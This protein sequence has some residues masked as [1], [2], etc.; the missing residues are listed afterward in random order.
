MMT[1]TWLS[2]LAGV[3][4]GCCGPG[5][6]TGAVGCG[7]LPSLGGLRPGVCCGA[8]LAV[9]VAWAWVARP[10]FAVSLGDMAKEA[11]DDL[12]TVPLLL[13]IAFYI[14][15]ATIVGF[16]LLKLKRHVDQPQQ[17]TIGSGL[18]AIG[19]GAALIAAPALVNALADTFGLTSGSQTLTRPKF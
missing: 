18:V 5:A 1:K 14:V 6:K 4:R 12:E 3:W 7:R 15:G 19:I 10:V 9:G 8:L 13:E 11:A 2:G 17:T 16:G